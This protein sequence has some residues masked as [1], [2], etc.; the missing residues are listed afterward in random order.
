MQHGILEPVPA[1]ARY[2]SFALKPGADPRPGL[3]A[4]AAAVD[5][6]ATVAGVGATLAAELSV[7]VPGLR[8]FPPLVGAGTELPSTPAALWCWLRGDDPGELFHRAAAIAG[9][10]GPAY[11]LTE[12]LDAFRHQGGRDLTGYED[13][14][15]NPFGEAAMEAAIVR[16]AGRG[17]DGGSFVAVQRWRHDFAAIRAMTGRERDLAIGRRLVDNTE[18]DD[19]PASAH[20][21]RTAQ[22]DFEPAAFTLRRSMPWVREGEGGLQFV[23]FGASFDAFEAQLR[24][25]IGMD[26][27]LRD[28]VFG[29]SQP[30]SGAYFWCPPAED[31]CLDLRVLGL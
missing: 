17:L 27:G 22:E 19:A 25:M 31:G 28:A 24:R 29:M 4:L 26:D 14:T 13:G 12:A 20:V 23:S 7:R 2:L 9:H 8:P 1:H 18:I 15:E 30:V 10:L 21:K 5:G 11:R 16:G 6:R 3:R